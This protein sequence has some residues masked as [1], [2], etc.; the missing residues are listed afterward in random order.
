LLHGKE[1][2]GAP[3]HLA[4]ARILIVDDQKPNVSLLEQIL[5]KAGYE[6]VRSTTDSRET[7][8]IF[9][10][11]H[12]DLILLDLLMPHL[13]GVDVMKQLRP[14][15]AVRSLPP[16]LI[17]TADTTP[18]AKL[19]ALSAGAKDFL[20][21]PFDRS[22]VLLRIGNLLETRLLHRQLESINDRLEQEVAKRTAQLEVARNEAL[23]RLAI[24]AEH[25]DDDT[26]NHIQRVGEISGQVARV[27]G[28]SPNEAELIRR[29]A[30]LHDVGKIGIPDDI[31]L[32]PGKFTPAEREQMQT[33]SL[34]GAKILSGSDSPL[35]Q[36][37]EEIAL[38]HHER[39]DG[40]GYPRGL[41]GA[42]IPRSARIVAVVDVFDAL[43]HH[44][45]YKAAWPVDEAVA[46]LQRQRSQQ[47]D[48]DVV[49][50][51]IEVHAEPKVELLEGHAAHG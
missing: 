13:D 3:R 42:E 29:A 27:L 4:P 12:P 37:A 32:K 48:P 35:L 1:P 28:P 34:M 22:E 8:S 49:D 39:W 6:N 14:H 43:T 30:T 9:K 26:G 46:E 18:E 25:R 17:L 51:F 45:P 5:H 40:S 11:F 10:E 2:M 33:H 19:R 31:L 50:A 47:F 21:K 24:A 36:M 44:R 15:A 20:T 23:E 41:R 7:L 38:N 16:I